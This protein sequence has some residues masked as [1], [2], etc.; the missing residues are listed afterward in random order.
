MLAAGR[1]GDRVMRLIVAYL[2]IV[3]AGLAVSYLAGR[4]VENWSQ[5]VSLFVFLGAF[6]FTL[7]FGWKLAVRVT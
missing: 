5:T 3:A 6:G 1:F 2:A 7:W 4:I